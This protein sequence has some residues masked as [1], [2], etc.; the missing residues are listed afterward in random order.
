MELDA[1]AVATLVRKQQ[2][3]LVR[4]KV[5]PEWAPASGNGDPAT[6]MPQLKDGLLLDLRLALRMM[7]LGGNYLRR[8]MVFV[9]VQ[10]CSL[11]SWLRCWL[12]WAATLYRHG[13]SGAL[14][15][16]HVDDLL[17]TGPEEVMQSIMKGIEEQVKMKWI[18]LITENWT[19]Y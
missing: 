1:Y 4:R 7:R 13:K 17:L 5:H 14:I 12:D 3:V 11:S 19:T 10:G 15:A 18:G 6:F 16:S 9:Q 2:H 8:S